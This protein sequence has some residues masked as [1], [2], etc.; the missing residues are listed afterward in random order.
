MQNV[1]IGIAGK[2]GSGKS[3]VLKSIALDA[4]RLLVWDLLGE[5]RWC[6]NPLRNEREI[7]AFI[8]WAH[9]R[10][11]FAA[12]VVPDDTD[13]ETFEALCQLAYR[14]GRLLLVIEEVAM[15]SKP[16][17]LPPSLDKIVRL[18][19]HRGV[20]VA[21]TTQRLSEVARRLTSTTDAFLLFFH[22]EPRDVEAIQ[23]RCGIA[24]ADTVS[25]LGRHNFVSWDVATGRIER[26]SFE[27]FRG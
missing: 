3:T 5:H 19:R 18:G 16:N 6:P 27:G 7:S 4:P 26:D 8:S 14:E 21:W 2:R 22:H 20:S 24:V 17:W 12:R 9:G 10:E 15:I 23:Q 1:V 13:D 11:R 25:Q